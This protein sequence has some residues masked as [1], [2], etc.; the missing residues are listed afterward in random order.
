MG[1]GGGCCIGDCCVANCGFC[2]I[3]DFFSSSGSGCCVGNC[4]VS[5]CGSDKSEEKHR[6]ENHQAAI[7]NELAKM[8]KRSDKD[9]KK[10]EE[11]II[12]DTNETMEEFIKWIQNDVNKRKIG[13]KTLSINIDKIRELNDDLRKKI[14][15]FIGKRLADRL[16]QT[17]PEVSTILAEYDDAKRKKNFDAFYEDRKREAIREL[18]KEIETSVRE[19]SDNIERE[20]QN[21]IKELNN[22]MTQETQALEEL[23]KLKSQEDSR[24]AEK[25]V[26]YMYYADLC[27]IMFNELKLSSLNLGR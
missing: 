27:G 9:A 14:V 16:I 6:E 20:I 11:D 5:D 26:E 4:C 1:G 2:C 17:D 12:T 15:G 13:G 7:A 10:Q 23:R 8:R 25:Q 3:G 18:I 21:R 22:S 19:Q 24:L